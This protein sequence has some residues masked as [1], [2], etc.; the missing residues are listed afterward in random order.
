LPNL[1][2]QIVGRCSCLVNFAMETAAC[3]LEA[4]DSR[5]LGARA[6][7]RRRSIINFATT[8]ARYLY[9]IYTRA[10]GTELRARCSTFDVS[11]FLLAPLLRLLAQ[12]FEVP[13]AREF[14][15]SVCIMEAFSP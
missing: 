13:D 10:R 8:A 9:I 6:Q 14:Y 1:G 11:L 3:G 12:K 2:C 15:N 7:R 5:L 4:S